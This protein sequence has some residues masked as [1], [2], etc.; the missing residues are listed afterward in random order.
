MFFRCLTHNVERPLEGTTHIMMYMLDEG[1]PRELITGLLSS[2]RSLFYSFGYM[3][4]CFIAP[5]FP[6]YYFFLVLLIDAV[7]LFTIYMVL[8]WGGVN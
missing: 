8:L 7:N 6:S 2:C 4:Y 1:A 3:P 5:L